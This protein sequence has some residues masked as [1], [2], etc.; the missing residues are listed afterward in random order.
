MRTFL[1][2]AAPFQ[3]EVLPTLLPVMC[4]NRHSVAEGLRNYSQQTW[5]RAMGDSGRAWV[6]RCIC[7]VV[8]SASHAEVAARDIGKVSLAAGCKVPVQEGVGSQ[9]FCFL[10]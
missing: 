4:F 5:K 2:A 1:E 10:A 9:G 3:E 8:V 6:A 7:Q